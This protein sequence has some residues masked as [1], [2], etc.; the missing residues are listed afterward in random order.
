[1]PSSRSPSTNNFDDVISDRLG[2]E[3][4]SSEAESQQRSP[5]QLARLA[6]MVACGALRLPVDLPPKQLEQLACEI[7]TRRRKNLVGFIAR[8]IAMDIH[9]SC[10]P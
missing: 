5:E 7:R 2:K 8:T 10:E 3:L 9:R 4:S 1:M 6:D